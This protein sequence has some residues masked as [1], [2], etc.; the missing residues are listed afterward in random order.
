MKTNKLNDLDGGRWLYFTNTI[1][2][3][4]YPPDAT[5]QL[6]KAHGAMKPPRAMAEL[7]EFFTHK[8]GQV[9]DPFAGVGGTLLGAELAGRW[10][11]GIELNPRWIE[12]FDNIAG[13]YGISGGELVRLNGAS[14]RRIRSRIERGSCL[15]VLPEMEAGSVDACICD[16]PYGPGQGR[17]SFRKETNFDMDTDDPEDFGNADSVEDF[18][19]LMARTGAEVHR[20]LKPQRYFVI[21]IG[22]RYMGGEFLPLGYLTAQK[23]RT[24]GFELKGMKI[25]WNA[26]TQRRLKPYG[27]GNCFVPNITHQNV[28]ILRRR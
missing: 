5:H 6:R 19:T 18:L 26:A 24:V 7:V 10:G 1:W 4:D 16:P 21:L 15:E 25:W 28:V 14:V 13:A 2:K 17:V 8:G 9:V 12:V 20:V 3:T 11:V 23:M 22:D 27:L